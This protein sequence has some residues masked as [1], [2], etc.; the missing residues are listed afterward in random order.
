MCFSAR[1][2]VWL[3]S[4]VLSVSSNQNDSL[5]LWF[6]AGN[7]KTVR[8]AGAQPMFQPPISSTELAPVCQTLLVLEGSQALCE[9]TGHS[10]WPCCCCS[11]QDG[12]TFPWLQGHVAGSSS[13]FYLPR[14]PS[15]IFFPLFLI[16]LLFLTHCYAILTSSAFWT[17][18]DSWFYFS[19][20][21][22]LVEHLSIP[23]AA[24]W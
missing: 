13:P 5:S 9:G 4:T 18:Q 6:P 2:R 12:C 22:F 17:F 3:N 20:T 16:C 10:C 1:V 8:S 14:P 15:P 11:A 23:S 21:G 19:F 24:W 7:W